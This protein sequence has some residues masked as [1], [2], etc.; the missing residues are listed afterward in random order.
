MWQRRRETPDVASTTK[1]LPDSVP[2]ASSVPT[3]PSVD[4][5]LNVPVFPGGIQVTQS[6]EPTRTATEL[7]RTLNGMITSLFASFVGDDG[8]TVNYVALRNATEF[9]DYVR[10]T[11]ALQVFVLFVFE[12]TLPCFHSGLSADY[13]VGHP[14]PS[15]AQSILLEHLQC[16]GKRVCA[17]AAWRELT[18]P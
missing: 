3:T 4:G 9:H 6:A 18:Q 14:F 10:L 2:A 13:P 8:K 17:C 12:P 1:K 5:P 16:H 7:A 11:A 15:G